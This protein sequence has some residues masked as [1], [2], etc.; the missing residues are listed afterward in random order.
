MNPKSSSLEGGSGNSDRSA[1]TWCR[2]CHK[3]LCSAGGSECWQVHHVTQT[4]GFW[5]QH[6][7][8][9]FFFKAAIKYYESTLVNHIHFSLLPIDWLICGSLNHKCS[10]LFLWDF[11]LQW[12]VA[13]FI[14]RWW[15]GASQTIL[16]FCRSGDVGFMQLSSLLPILSSSFINTRS[17]GRLARNRECLRDL[18]R[19][20]LD[21][22]GWFQA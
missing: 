8:R 20:R 17:L 12:N 10:N 14:H 3:E 15:A 11:F 13:A 6:I 2:V 5:L 7:W 19:H 4:L 1:R 9:F 16:G 22:V 18:K 21:I